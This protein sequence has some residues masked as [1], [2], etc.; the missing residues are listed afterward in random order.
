MSVKVK[1]QRYNCPK[2]KFAL[3]LL[4]AIYLSFAL[5]Y[6]IFFLRFSQALFGF[7]FSIFVGGS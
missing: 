1:L 3:P 2:E 7:R 5:F 4:S 6:F